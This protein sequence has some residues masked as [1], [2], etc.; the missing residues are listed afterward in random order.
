MF[1]DIAY[2]V[3]KRGTCD[4]ARV[5]A[6]LTQENRIISIGYNG[7]KPGEPHCDE[8]G[9]LIKN[10]HCVRTTHAEVN[11]LMYARPNEER[12]SPLTLY[13]THFPCNNCIDHIIWFN[14]ITGEYIERIVYGQ[15]YGRTIDQIEFKNKLH[16]E[17][18]VLIEQ[19]PRM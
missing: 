6:V 10:G 4:R 9:H 5:G 17:E 8:A 2:I 3:A 11:C 13:V 1:M 18:G 14:K 15:R 7:S 19:L 16:A 12:P